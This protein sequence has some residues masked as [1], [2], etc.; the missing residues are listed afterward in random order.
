MAKQEKSEEK[1]SNYKQLARHFHTE[2]EQLRSSQ[3][4]EL[5]AVQEQ[6]KHVIVEQET[7][8]N[9]L[10]SELDNQQVLFNE[11]IVQYETKLNELRELNS[12]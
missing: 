2:F 11:Q 3:N 1:K 4:K 10:K 6:M 5:E 8:I 12:K 7:S 9:T